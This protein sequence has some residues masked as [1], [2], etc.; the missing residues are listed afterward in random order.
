MGEAVAAIEQSI[1]GVKA[2][3][4]IDFELFLCKHL[5]ERGLVREVVVAFFIV[6]DVVVFV[7]RERG[8]DVNK[9]SLAA[10]WISDLPDRTM[11]TVMLG[12]ISLFVNFLA[13][14]EAFVG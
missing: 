3:R 8:F 1:G 10:A 7:A 6:K 14:V 5:V 2:E 4:T 9:Y 13:G 11:G 12:C